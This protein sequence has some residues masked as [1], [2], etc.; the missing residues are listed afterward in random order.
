MPS[1]NKFRFTL[2]VPIKDNDGKSLRDEVEIVKAAILKLAGG[3]TLVSVLGTWL[4]ETTG[5]VYKDTSVKVE[6]I[7]DHFAQVEDLQFC[8]RDWCSLLRQHS[9]LTT[10]EGVGV[11]F[12]SPR[13]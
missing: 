8:C 2:T 6:V 10:W 3:Y 9:L 7:V 5:I 11:N 4:D 1:S 12:W 13:T